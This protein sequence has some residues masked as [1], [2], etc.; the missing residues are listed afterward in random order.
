MKKGQV[1]IETVL[2][3]LIGL[4]L[5]GIALGFIMP[6]INETRDRVLVEQAAS[7]LS[8][9][10]EK[11]NEV[12]QKGIGNVRENEFMMK[13]GELYFNSSTDEILF[14]IRDLGRPYSQPGVEIPQGR[15]TI[16]TVTEQKGN[17]V[18]IKADYRANI[19][20]SGKE[21]LV[22]FSA[23]QIPYKFYIENK[24]NVNTNIWIDIDEGSNR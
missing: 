23:A 15:I 1:W 21:E 7:S 13:K 24:G 9:L 8:V 22:K 20:F 19:T 16:K 5:I 10:D 6:K 3:T 2:Y 11:I 18:Y 12:V 17:S 4:A 14:V